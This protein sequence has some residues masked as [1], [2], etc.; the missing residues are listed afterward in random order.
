MRERWAEILSFT[1][2]LFLVVGCGSIEPAI[3]T[4]NDMSYN[5]IALETKQVVQVS[6]ISPVVQTH[7]TST[8]FAPK[9]IYGQS[10]VYG[11]LISSM[12]QIPIAETAVY[13]THGVGEHNDLL[14]P[15]LIGP[16]DNDI[17]TF[18]DKQGNYI[19]SNMPPGI[20]YLIIWSPVNWV[21]LSDDTD[22]DK[23]FKIVLKEDQE[24]NV[25]EIIV[26][27]P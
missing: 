22:S 17:L 24:I 6:P 10:M 4:V 13:L 9:S 27:W 2:I 25:G 3:P 15:V 5:P 20:Y 26:N 14:P 16:Q 8:P 19:F 11:K 21:P 1:T 12:T 7:I 18:T 23:P